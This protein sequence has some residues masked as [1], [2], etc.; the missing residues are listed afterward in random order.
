MPAWL[1]PPVPHVPGQVARFELDD[2]REVVI[3]EPH[4]VACSSGAG[5]VAGF[6]IK[7]WR[8]GRE[9]AATLTAGDLV[10]V[11]GAQDAIDAFLAGD[12]ARARR[13]V[14]RASGAWAGLARLFRE[15]VVS[16][17][18]GEQLRRS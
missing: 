10:G 5:E 17:P 2:R 1:P 4:A 14:A 9:L 18:S 6:R 8:P 13:L 7:V 15:V 3:H 11:F 12:L 16:R